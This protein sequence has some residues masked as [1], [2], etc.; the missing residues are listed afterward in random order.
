MCFIEDS[1]RTPETTQTTD[2]ADSNPQK[3]DPRAALTCLECGYDLRSLPRNGSCPECGTSIRLSR[4]YRSE[5]LTAV[6]QLPGL[7]MIM[8]WLCLATLTGAPALLVFC[9]QEL[10]AYEVA[11]GGALPRLLIGATPW[12]LLV[13]SIT[14]TFTVSATPKS[15]TEADAR[16]RLVMLLVILGSVGCGLML[17]AGPAAR[18]SVILVL[19]GTLSALGCAIGLGTV[20]GVI[21]GAIPQ[22]ERMGSAD[23]RRTAGR[24]H[25][26][27]DPARDDPQRPPDLGPDDLDH[28]RVLIG[29]ETPLAI[30]TLYLLVNRLWL[31]NSLNQARRVAKH[32]SRSS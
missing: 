16:K 30:G 8:L 23:R 27:R 21:G 7:P 31:A 6:H 19:G 13:G 26:D 4:K 9:S 22:W 18:E 2:M 20:S 1:P 17:W 12:L 32:R 10:L 28:A 5:I 3:P 15:L 24:C 14:P 25:Y 29:T 11:K